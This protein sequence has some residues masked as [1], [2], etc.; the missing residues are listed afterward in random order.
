MK[1]VLLYSHL[2]DEDTEAQS[3]GVRDNEVVS[4]ATILVI[5]I[6][7]EANLS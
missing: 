7:R 5:V 2:M 4:K 6:K 3:I 1:L